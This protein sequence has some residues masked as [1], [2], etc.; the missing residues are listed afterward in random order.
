MKPQTSIT[1]H[2]N[3]QSKIKVMKDTQDLK[4][5]IVTALD[6]IN[7][8]LISDIDNIDVIDNSQML[9]FPREQ[10]D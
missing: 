7:Q 10:G 5:A 4:V 6:S 8:D 3:N 2:F 1:I 9:L